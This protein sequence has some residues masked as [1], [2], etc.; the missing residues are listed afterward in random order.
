MNATLNLLSNHSGPSAPESL[1]TVPSATVLR[2]GSARSGVLFDF[3]LSFTRHLNYAARFERRCRL[4]GAHPS[5]DAVSLPGQVGAV[6]LGEG[7]KAEIIMIYDYVMLCYG[8]A[9]PN[10]ERSG[11]ALA[12]ES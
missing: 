10:A 11:T 9:Q 8:N 3:V 5:I 2:S 6:L 7:A 4:R 1:S 12:T